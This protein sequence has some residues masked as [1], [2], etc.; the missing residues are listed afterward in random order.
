MPKPK[1]HDQVVL[2]MSRDTK[3]F[4]NCMRGHIGDFEVLEKRYRD[5]FRRIR[6][7]ADDLDLEGGPC[8]ELVIDAAA[9]IHHQCDAVL[10]KR[11]K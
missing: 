8:A 10:G 9:S 5:R 2:A 4:V 7:A 1:T 6:R 3:A 11:E